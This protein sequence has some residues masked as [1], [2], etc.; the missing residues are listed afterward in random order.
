MEKKKVLIAD[1]DESIL[2][3]LEKFFVDKGLKVIKALDG[4]ETARLIKEPDLTLAVIDINMPGRSGLSVLKDVQ[5]T[6]SQVQVIIMTAETTMKNTLEAMK[7][8]AFDYITKPFDLEELDITVNRVLENITL[9]AKLS[10]LTD[11]LKEKLA[12]ETTFI[13][14]SAKIQSVFK[15]AGKTATKDVSILILGES[16]TGKELLAK[17]IHMNSPRSDN[18]FITINSAAVPRELMES[19]LFGS[20]KG[21]FT[22]AT[23]RKLG[24]FELA[25]KGTL[26][27]DEV[28]DMSPE[29]QARLLR[30]TQDGEFFRVGGKESIKVDV[31]IIAATNKNLDKEVA[32]ER[33]REDLLFR[34]NGITLTLPPLRERK[35]D[36]KLLSEF[37]LEKY[38]RKFD[39]E[40]RTLTPEALEA[41]KEYPWPGNVRELENVLRRGVL[42]CPSLAL[43]PLD[44]NLP[45]SKDD[46]GKTGSL[47]DIITARL[48]PF[49]DQMDLRGARQLYGL[50][51]PYLER[52]LIR[53]VLEKTRGNQVHTAD[54]LGINRN[55]LRKKIKNLK[56][57]LK[58]IKQ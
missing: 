29:L 37:F 34:L 23:E 2:W 12:D 21:A 31:R 14:K 16:G 11:R 48:R 5:S 42:L 41:L 32:E 28:G 54:A 52:P 17:L 13:G 50:V 57:N 51:M 6:T 8:G 22:G 58:K 33:F 39:C 1:D 9:K 40:P 3:V 4:H 53:L 20:E 55:T 19:E 27:M 36:I 35:S 25:D 26:F 43:G 10:I 45:K 46:G 7:L 47:E 24:K 18:Q 30:V 44:L 38:A 15:A 56:I 49:I